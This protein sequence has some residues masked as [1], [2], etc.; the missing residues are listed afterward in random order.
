MENPHENTPPR[1]RG[2]PPGSKNKP[3]PAQPPLLRSTGPGA[4]VPP[5]AEPPA[6]EHAPSVRARRKPPQRAQEPIPA[7]LAVIAGRSP[8]ATEPRTAPSATRLLETARASLASGVEALDRCIAEVNHR[9]ATAENYDLRLASHLA[10]ITKHAAGLVDALR[11][12]EKHDAAQADAMPPEERDR[13][14]ADY[15]TELPVERRASFRQLL[16]DLDGRRML[17]AQ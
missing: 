14:V 17:L 5:P 13:M 4:D 1:R 10:W 2:R 9:L 16:E 15:L 3:K 8:A 7:P 6:G 12:L 11:K